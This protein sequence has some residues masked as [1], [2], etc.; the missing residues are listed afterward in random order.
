[1]PVMASSLTSHTAQCLASVSTQLYSPGAWQAEC[2]VT[3][4][5]W[6]MGAYG[7]VAYGQ[8]TL[9]YVMA[10]HLSK[11]VSCLKHWNYSLSPANFLEKDSKQP[12]STTIW[13]LSFHEDD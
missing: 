12:S 7:C 2:P 1:M 8:A 13:F 11:P 4:K 10:I 5:F 9:G 3:H 6:L